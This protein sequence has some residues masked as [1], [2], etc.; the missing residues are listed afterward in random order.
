VHYL[1][2]SHTKGASKDWWNWRHFMH[3]SKP[4]II[5]KDP[6]IAIA[7]L[8][9]IGRRLSQIWGKKKLGYMPYSWQHRYWHFI[10][11]P[12]LVPF[13]FQY[14]HLTWAIKNKRWVDLFWCVTFYIKYFS[15]YVPVIGW[16]HAIGLYFFMRVVESHWFVYVT[17]MNH[18]PMHI[19]FDSKSDGRQFKI[20]PP[21]TLRAQCSI[22]GSQAI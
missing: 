12:L 13:Y 14:E 7:H 6:D 18:L 10:G 17:Q 21:A 9:V 3:H 20:W 11:P 5:Q 22:P 1:T 15:I 2:L 8:F 4:N 16:W 19:D